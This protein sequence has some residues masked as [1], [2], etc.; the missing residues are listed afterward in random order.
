MSNLLVD[1]CKKADSFWS[2]KLPSFF[3]PSQSIPFTKFTE[4]VPGKVPPELQKKIYEAFKGMPPSA[5]A[6]NWPAENMRLY[7]AEA[8]EASLKFQILRDKN[9]NITLQHPD[10]PDLIF[11]YTSPGDWTKY[12]GI[13]CSVGPFKMTYY[14]MREGLT[15]RLDMAERARIAKESNQLDL[16]SI[17]KKQIAFISRDSEKHYLKVGVIE[18][19]ELDRNGLDRLN[20]LS[21]MKAYRVF[22]Q[23]FTLI[24]DTGLID[25]SLKDGN[26]AFLKNQDKVAFI[27]TER[28]R[29]DS[30]QQGGMPETYV[31]DFNLD[32]SEITSFNDNITL[33]G[34]PRN[35]ELALA[36]GVIKNL[37]EETDPFLNLNKS[38]AMR[39]AYYTVIAKSNLEMGANFLKAWNYRAFIPAAILFGLKSVLK[40]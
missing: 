8:V 31:K 7:S 3:L 39:A 26:I 6:W 13:N 35:G 22:S 9:S 2:Q 28:W 37:F 23:V 5:M 24:K 11:K 32:L 34:G 14:G 19:L 12:P 27:D 16:I 36:Q 40:F 25:V 30:L 33:L 18:K 17:P 1:Y 15:S 10:M 4:T 20:Q 38:L 21:F 29:V